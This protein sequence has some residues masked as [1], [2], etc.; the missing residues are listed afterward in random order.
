MCLDKDSSIL[1]TDYWRN[2]IKMKIIL[3]GTLYTV[4]VIYIMFFCWFIDKA[5][6]YATGEN[7]DRND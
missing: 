2:T 1:R 4:A 7:N 3:Y 5:A 6:K